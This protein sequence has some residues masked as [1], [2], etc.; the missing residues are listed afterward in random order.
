MIHKNFFSKIMML[1]VAIVAMSMTMVSCT[2]NDDNAVNTTD[3]DP[4]VEEWEGKTAK[5][6]IMFYGCG[7]GDVDSQLTGAI[8]YLQECLGEKNNQVRFVVMYSMSKDDSMYRKEAEKAGETYT[9]PF[10][11]EYGAWGETYRY[12]VTPYI[13]QDNYR[14]NGYYKQAKDVE[15]Y[16]VETIKEFINW[17]KETAPAENYILMPTNHGGGFDLDE[18]EMVS[19]E[20]Q[21]RAIGYDN[22]QKNS[23]GIPTKAFAQALKET[24]TH[25]K[26]VYWN[27]CMMAQ[28]EVMTEMAPYCDYQFCG[29]H[30][31]Y[32]LPRHAYAIVDA[33]NAYPSAD[34]FEL[35][36]KCQRDILDGPSK[37][38]NTSFSD[39]L[40]GQKIDDTMFD[41]NGDYGCWR[42]AGLAA[43]NAQVRKLA[44][45]LTEYYEVD[46]TRARIEQA[47]RS[48][49]MF[50]S[51]SVYVDVLDYAYHLHYNLQSIDTESIYNELENA[52]NVANV[53]QIC[54]LNRKIVATD[55]ETVYYK[56]PATDRYS[57]G[58]SLYDNNNETW[59]EYARV[60]KASAF[61]KATGW[62]TFLDKNVQKVDPNVNPANAS[63]I[64]PF[65]MAD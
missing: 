56:W 62:S 35:A 40:K 55:G 2:A 7:G 43:I 61:D 23:P 28:L 34:E 24:N 25:L 65:W 1:C 60:Y 8:P 50:D 31:Q 3:S 12:E 17:A 38:N 53:Y 44:D 19:D 9:G 58:I 22:N 63:S 39:V 10:D 36:A 52:L 51:T 54:C 30:V 64:I 46:A 59:E 21:T 20:S 48:V 27:G 15:L 29:A 4:Y 11:P 42:S 45:M 5:Y 47:T 57:L 18:E 49:Y 6:T 14:E 26:A 32:A 13:T 41:A 16:E 33:L 37:G